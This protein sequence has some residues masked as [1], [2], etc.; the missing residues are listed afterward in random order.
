[1]EAISQGDLA[2]V[3]M[4]NLTISQGLCVVD[5]L[6]LALHVWEV[7]NFE[8]WEQERAAKRVPAQDWVVE[9]EQDCFGLSVAK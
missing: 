4:R 6:L 1:M 7:R 8:L 9:K 2:A 3:L 5:A